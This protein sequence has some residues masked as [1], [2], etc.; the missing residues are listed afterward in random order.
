MPPKPKFTREEIVAAALSLLREQGESALTAREIGKRLGTS[1]SPIFTTFK[2]MEE[3]KAAVQLEAK[4]V[5]D[6]YMEVAKAF[7]PAYKKRGMQWVKF[8]REEPMLFRLLFEQHSRDGADLDRALSELPFGREN[9]LEIIMRDYHATH[10]QAAHL[11]RQ[12]WIYTYGL[13]VISAAGICSLTDAE[14]AALLGEIFR[15]MIHILHE[16]S[17]ITKIQPVPDASEAGDALRRRSP[18]L[19]GK[20]EE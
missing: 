19:R 10:E 14:I 2:D 18:D 1:S 15:G 6:R 17:D 16:G 8:A 12:M 4:A 3:L 13:C 7:F 11:F 9:D 20:G 5:F